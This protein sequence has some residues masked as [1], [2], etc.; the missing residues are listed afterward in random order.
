MSH[1][2]IS[3]FV[4][5]PQVKRKIKSEIEDTEFSHLSIRSQIR[6]EDNVSTELLTVSG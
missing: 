5:I 3:T 2:M 4:T 1:E 6:G